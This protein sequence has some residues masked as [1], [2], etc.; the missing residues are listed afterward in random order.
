MA[1]AGWNAN[2]WVNQ[3]ER[4]LIDTVSINGTNWNIYTKQAELNDLWGA[5]NERHLLLVEA[6]AGT[7]T[8][9]NWESSLNEWIEDTYY[10]SVREAFNELKSRAGAMMGANDI[11]TIPASVSD[12]G[13]VDYLGQG[14]TNA[15][16]TRIEPSIYDTNSECCVGCTDE[17]D[18]LFY[19]PATI[20][21]AAG[22][23][24]G[25][26]DT[27]QTPWRD[28]R[29]STNGFRDLKAVII[30]MECCEVIFTNTGYSVCAVTNVDDVW[31]EVCVTPSSNATCSGSAAGS[32]T[33]TTVVGAVEW[34]RTSTYDSDAAFIFGPGGPYYTTNMPV[35]EYWSNNYINADI[36]YTEWSLP[37]SWTSINGKATHFFLYDEPEDLSAPSNTLFAGVVTDVTISATC[38]IEV[39][40][41]PPTC[42]ADT[43]SEWADADNNAYADN[44]FTGSTEY[45]ANFYGESYTGSGNVPYTGLTNEA[46]T[47]G[48]WWL[49][50]FGL[51]NPILEWCSDQMVEFD[52]G[53]VTRNADCE[54]DAFSAD[55]SL[56]LDWTLKG[57]YYEYSGGLDYRMFLDVDW[58]YE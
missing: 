25:F 35:T 23:N 16:T 58:E 55:A 54:C 26:W 53:S 12:W 18:P 13:N 10:R 41:D 11:W 51:E 30:Q 27:A 4:E 14:T 6:S 15:I 39:P 52:S 22:V 1:S 50:T 45:C 17:G 2:V 44:T 48:D 5:L 19:D 29:I 32:I 21:A 20:L 47:I 42:T 9:T 38:T 3:R 33:W 40:P 49:T 8:G 24:T 56:Q 46:P 57:D 34:D 37:V 36:I 31:S 28:I 43:E 7:Y